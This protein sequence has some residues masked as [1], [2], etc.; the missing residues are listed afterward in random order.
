MATPGASRM[1]LEDAHWQES[2]LTE[3]KRCQAVVVQPGSTTGVR[4][5]LEQIRRHVEPFRVLFCLVSYWKDP[6]SYEAMETI[7]REGL[8]M[9][10]PRV[11][12]FLDR[13]SFVYFDRGWL[14]RVQQL[15]Y[16]NPVLWPLTADAADLHY[17][18]DPFVQGMDGEEREGPRALRWRRGIG[19]SLADVAAALI[20]LI[21]LFV[22]VV[23]IHLVAKY[24]V[25]SFVSSRSRLDERQ[26]AD[27]VSRS[28]RITL[29]GRAVPYRFE[30]PQ[31]LITESPE[32][33]LVEHS[34][35]S[36]DNLLSIQVLAH[37]QREDLTTVAQARLKM[38]SGKGIAESKLESERTIKQAG[39][40]WV[41]CQIVAKL[42]NGIAAKEIF[43]A[44]SG[45]RGSVF[46]VTMLLGSAV[47]DPVYNHV[48]EEIF[49]S[50]RFAESP[51]LSVEP[52]QAKPT[53]APASN[54]ALAKPEP[55]RDDAV[56]TIA[57]ESGRKGPAWDA[58]R[59]RGHYEIGE[60]KIRFLFGSRA[61]APEGGKSLPSWPDIANYAAQLDGDLH[62]S[63]D[64]FYYMLLERQT[65]LVLRFK[66]LTRDW[67]GYVAVYRTQDGSYFYKGNGEDRPWKALA[68]EESVD[69]HWKESDKLLVHID[70]ARP[71]QNE[72]E[73][74]GEVDYRFRLEEDSKER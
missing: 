11:V 2:V 19:K 38:N 51:A 43:R 50:F 69:L 53:E 15:S 30:L 10:L 37:K 35:R 4:W 66:N 42:E 26:K 28:P 23:T 21:I 55:G 29:E 18:L 12:P 60:E 25:G 48:A 14:P 58:Q 8:G 27:V 9:E 24:A 34:R 31:A 74:D 49:A 71:S 47:T 72:H 40:E 39:V 70:I 64:P 3:L 52:A 13:P 45:D 41:E 54:A 17:T 73:K 59:P 20:A 56:E 68:K 65:L 16:K 22:P 5:E 7:S 36:P 46:V 62:V 1:Y 33:E 63:G 44:T 61:M 67:D 32:N 6:Q 57:G